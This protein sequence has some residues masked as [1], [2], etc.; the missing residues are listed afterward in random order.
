MEYLAKKYKIQET[1][2]NKILKK[3]LVDYNFH[4]LGWNRF[5][6]ISTRPLTLNGLDMEQEFT[7]VNY[8]HDKV[9][10]IR[11]IIII[12]EEGE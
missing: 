6:E 12:R 11:S 3:E 5:L 4:I 1:S 10:T 2:V 9:M 8:I 7:L